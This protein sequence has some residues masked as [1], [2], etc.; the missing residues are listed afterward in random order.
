MKPNNVNTKEY[1]LQ[2]A[3]IRFGEGVYNP[4]FGWLRIFGRGLQWKHESR[5]L[6]FSERN[7]YRK[8]IKIRKWII[9][10]LP[11]DKNKMND[12]EL[13][14]EIKRMQETS[15]LKNDYIAAA[16][17]GMCSCRHPMPLF[18]GPGR[19]YCFKCKKIRE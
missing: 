5:G 12:K 9:R 16:N 17:N 14:R 7:G 8:Y 19:E 2:I 11:K 10:Y 18:A 1:V 6:L 13:D 3:G 4:K 15:P